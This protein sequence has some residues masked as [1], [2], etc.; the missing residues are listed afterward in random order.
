MNN[1]SP[2]VSVIIPVYN[3]E[4]YIERSIT[5][6]L[7]QT[8]G[9]VE[10]I[11]VNDGSS[12]NSLNVM[13]RYSDRCVI[14][15]KENGGASTARNEGIRCANGKYLY[16]M[17]ADDVI[18]NNAIELLVH[19]METHNS[20]MCCFRYKTIDSYG[21]ETI[22]GANYSYTY[23][24]KQECIIKDALLVKNIKTAPWSR[25]YRTDIIKN[26]GIIFI[27]GII[28][29]DS[30]FTDMLVPKLNVVTFINDVL[31]TIEQRGGSV[32][33]TYNSRYITSYFNNYKIVKEYYNSMGLYNKYRNYIQC[34]YVTSVLFAL[35]SIAFGVKNFTAFKELYSYLNSENFYNNSLLS[36]VKLKGYSYYLLSL[37]S[38][39]PIL[40]Y[41]TMRSLKFIGVKRY[42]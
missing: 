6:I 38:Y 19:N 35:V 4:E 11:L 34:Q 18:S 39:S 36:N 7:S 17:D 9:N 8:Y 5:C 10:L 3:V 31:Y 2:L 13:E 29:E 30:V 25:M 15:N 12:D 20:D 42:C 27:D 14:I 33:R 24:N 21:N 22:L 41:L 37:L 32:S 26:N 40:F 1:K 16:F 28:N 23:L